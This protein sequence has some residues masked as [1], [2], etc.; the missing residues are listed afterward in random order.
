MMRPS[1]SFPPVEFY[2][3]VRP[4]QAANSRP[5]RNLVGS[6]A[7]AAIGLAVI[8]PIPGIDESN[9]VIGGVL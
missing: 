2:L 5:E 4:S 1:R 8:G 3:S 9:F 6:G 7:V